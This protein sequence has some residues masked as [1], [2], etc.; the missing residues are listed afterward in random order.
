MQTNTSH[1]CNVCPLA[2]PETLVQ[3]MKKREGLGNGNSS[4]EWKCSWFICNEQKWAPL[5]RR[6]SRWLYHKVILV[7]NASY[8]KPVNS[9]QQ[10][11][12]KNKNNLVKTRLREATTRRYT[13]NVPSLS[14]SSQSEHA[15]MGYTNTYEH[16]LTHSS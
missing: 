14:M 5:D 6:L 9:Q 3:A 16:R 1:C 4:I 15:K 13:V 7:L 8:T 2:I 11:L 10:K 12:N